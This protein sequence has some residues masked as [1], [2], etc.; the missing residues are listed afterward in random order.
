MSNDDLLAPRMVRMPQLAPGEWLNAAAP[1]HREQLRG[2]VVL[3]EFWDYACVNCLRTLPYLAQWHAR[4]AAAGLLIIGIHT[5]EFAFAHIRTLVET[6]VSTHHIQY[7]ILLDNQSENWDRF[8]NKA[9]P[10]RYLI[11]PDGY[12]RFQRRGEGYYQETERA[13]RRLL[14]QRDPDVALPPLLAP[15]RAEDAPGAVCYRPTPELHAGYQGGLF[16]G[17]LGNPAGYLPHTPVFYPLPEAAERSAGQFYVEGVWRAWPEALAYAGQGG[18]RILLPY[19]AA[20][21]NAVLSPTADPVALRLRL[22]AAAAEPVVDVRQD[23]RFL[24]PAIAGADV[25]HLP[26]GTS[27]IWVDQPRLYQLVRNPDF[28]WHELT[29]TFQATD[30]ALYAF[31]FT[32]CVAPDADAADPRTFQVN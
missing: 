27:R 20:T 24:D 5:P 29:L 18:G 17:A 21:V 14:R 23:G 6:A 10:T 15:L 28:G 12:I 13:I 4:Y 31:S 1:L 26:D 19:Q 3:V 30:L 11:D 25:Q 8:A 2:Q 22:H 16:G 32:S 7:P 9:W